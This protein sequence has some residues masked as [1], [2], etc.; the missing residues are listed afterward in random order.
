[1]IIIPMRMLLS[2]LLVVLI[3][4]SILQA[5]P[6]SRAAE[7]IKPSD[8]AAKIHATII[9]QGE[10]IGDVLRRLA[11]EARINMVISEHVQGTVTLKLEDKTPMEAIEIIATAKDLS[12]EKK[13]GVYFVDAKNPSPAPA[14]TSN[15]E[16]SL[17]DWAKKLQESI[18]PALTKLYE[19]LLDHDAR[20]ETA[21]RIARAKKALYDALIAEGFTK[22]EAFRLVLAHQDRSLQMGN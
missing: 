6:A 22:E 19:D 1:M 2:S 16:D 21:R 20:P 18:A 17:D 10:P 11:R 14:Q 5:E 15:K 13:D 7:P 3:S 12:I 9:A 8:P 4:A